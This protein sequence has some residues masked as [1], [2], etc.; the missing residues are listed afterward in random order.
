MADRITLQV[1]RYRPETRHDADHAGLR[2]PA[3]QGL[4]RPRWPEPHQGPRG[5]H[6][7]LPLV[8]P[9]G[10]LRELR[11]DRRRRAEADLCHVPDRLRPGSGTGR[12]ADQL[13][14][15]ARSRR[16]HRRL[17][18]QAAVRQ[19]VAHPR[20]RGA[21]GRRRVPPDRRRS[22]RRTSS[23]ACASTACS[24]TPPARS[25][26]S[27]QEFLGPAAIALAQRYNLDSRDQGGH[28]SDWTS[29]RRPKGSG[30]APSWASA[31]RPAPRTWTRPVPSSATRSPRPTRSLKSFLLPRGAAMSER[32][33]TRS[34]TARWYRPRV[35]VFWWLRRRSYLLFVLRELSSVFVAWFVVFLLLLVNAVA[36]GRA[37]VPAVPGLERYTGG[38]SR[39]TWSRCCF[40][41]L[42]A[43]TWFTLW[44]R[45]RWSYGCAAGA[46]RRPL[47]ARRALRGLDARLGARG[48]ADPGVNDGQ[49]TDRTVPVAA[50][51]RRRR[52]G[53][54][55]DPGPAVA[56]RRRV[57]AGLG[58]AARPCA[59]A[60]RAAPPGHAS[61]SPRP[62]RAG[63]LPLG[64]P[65][66]LHPL[67]TGCSS[68]VSTT[69]INLFCYGG[70]VVGT[71]L[72]ADLLLRAL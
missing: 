41:V 27:T 43:V 70:A 13:P 45:R 9:D 39:S 42:H 40:I 28:R 26:G 38:C 21:T 25:T 63:A 29:C 64:S 57:P 67:S 7:L 56:F 3:A 66:P 46:C 15:R 72:A 1:T 34:S 6:A 14:R 17:H 33:S 37:R 5:R 51:Q 8:L 47:I 23:S 54:A 48:L 30:T 62:L 65:L 44:R 20:G 22:W 10:H 61:R 32:S 68:S 11:H 16:R 60:R 4:V 50:V 58:G 55:A 19:A 69:S 49:A 12:A 53:G 59:P 31:A 52:A 35:P 71:L 24:A 2:D 18:G 36:Q